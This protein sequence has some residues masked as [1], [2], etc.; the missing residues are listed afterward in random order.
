MPRITH[1][2]FGLCTA[3]LDP[4]NK[5]SNFFRALKELGNLGL[6]VET[7]YVFPTNNLPLPISID[8]SGA[9]PK[10]Q[11][12]ES[13]ISIM[14]QYCPKVN[15]HSLNATQEMLEQRARKVRVKEFLAYFGEG[16]F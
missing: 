4:E 14:A 16:N 13:F 8:V 15:Y 3:T 10:S 9:I 5:I 7:F 11:I 2:T 1:R 6:R 12:D